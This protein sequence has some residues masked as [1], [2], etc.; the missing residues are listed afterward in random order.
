MKIDNHLFVDYF[1][2]NILI[3]TNDWDA[4]ETSW[5]FE[6]SPLLKFKAENLEDTYYNWEQAV[7]EDFMQ[8]HQNEEELNRIFIAIYDLAD[9]LTP[10]VPL[11]DITILQEE[12]DRK[13]LEKNEAQI[14]QTFRQ[15]GWQK[16]LLPL[17]QKTVAEQFVS[18]AIGCFTG[19]YRLD[20]PGLH[21]AHP[22]A[23]EAELQSYVLPPHFAEAGQPFEID[24]DG[25][26]PLMDKES[27]FADNALLRFRQMVQHIWGEHTLTQNLNFLESALGKSV[28]EYLQKDFA[29]YHYKTYKKRPIYWVFRSEKGSFQALVYMHRMN[30]YSV[31]KLRMNYLLKYIEQ[32]RQRIESL[33]TDPNRSSSDQKQLEKLE[34]Q[35]TECRDYD[36]L[37]EQTMRLFIEFDLD[38]GVKINYAKFETVLMKL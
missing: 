26:V 34:K 23:T 27:A 11:K 12:L 21:I 3:S 19:R 16:G 9:E 18:Y 2:L 24:A 10:N 22:N 20:K 6:Q 38:D 37:L 25:I 4:C 30:K 13:L 14:L 15:H 35:Y 1:N 33:N 7:S 8:L 31:Q 17:S 29:T 36:A 5:D 28:E 32:L